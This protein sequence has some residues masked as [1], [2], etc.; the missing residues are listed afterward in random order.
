[1]SPSGPE[2]IS[3]PD[4]RGDQPIS[5]TAPEAMTL[6]SLGAKGR[7]EAESP[8]PTGIPRRPMQGSPQ[9]HHPTMSHN[10]ACNSEV[11][12]VWVTSGPDQFSL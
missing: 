8:D 1:M 7:S 2:V 5:P 9:G 12:H 11:T 4:L 6:Y 3:P 10:K